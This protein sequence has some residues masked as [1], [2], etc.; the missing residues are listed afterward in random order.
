MKMTSNHVL[1]KIDWLMLCSFLAGSLVVG[2]LIIPT[3]LLLRHELQTI[4]QRFELQQWLNSLQPS[5]RPLSS[6]PI[7]IFNRLPED[8]A[9]PEAVEAMPWL[10]S[11]STYPVARQTMA[12]WIHFLRKCGAKQILID[13]D[14]ATPD[15]QDAELAREVVNARKGS[16]G[17]KAVPIHFVQNVVRGSYGNINMIQRVTEP[18]S[19]AE[20]IQIASCSQFKV[21]DFAGISVMLPDD[22]QVIRR[23]L[24]NLHSANGDHRSIIL[25][26]ARL[27]APHLSHT[28]PVLDINFIDEPNSAVFPVRPLT[29][30]VDPDRR[31]ELLTPNP[32]S[33]DVKINGAVVLIGDGISDVFNTPLTHRGWMQMS[34]TEI[35]AQAINSLV[36][37]SHITRTDENFDG[38]PSLVVCILS[39]TIAALAWL[40][41][42]RMMHRVPKPVPGSDRIF[43]F[44]S[45]IIDASFIAG[46]VVVS[47]FA[48]SL[49]FWRH[50]LL[51]PI[52]APSLAI[53]GGALT[54]IIAERNRE[55]RLAF[56]SQLELAKHELRREFVRRINHDLNAP[57]TV[58]NWALAD[59]EAINESSPEMKENIE[60]ML[61]TSDRLCM[62]L[63]EMSR[64]YEDNPNGASESIFDLREAISNSVGMLRPLAK[65]R[66]GQIECE[67]PDKPV[68]VCSP[69]PDLVRI[70]DNL[71]RN[72]FRHNPKGTMV[73][74]QLYDEGEEAEVSVSD[75]GVG[76]SAEKARQIFESPT[77][78]GGIYGNGH[79]M[80]LG[81]VKSL[82]K[83]LHG[84]I[85]L[86]SEHGKGACFN[87]RF[88]TVSSKAA[89]DGERLI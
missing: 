13:Q 88:P 85:R 61:R 54:A 50:Q 4:D 49:I 25:L 37:G 47:V 52:I 8:E 34:G 67:L 89:E 75:N 66:D 29:Y 64:T 53:V 36:S 51:I 76:I 2:L 81:I 41:W 24:L 80:G 6:T 42:C 77:P 28:D 57:V 63:D 1:R 40:L 21:D 14:F 68:Y 15:P 45:I 70:F 58:L 33:Q 82:V 39:S 43:R 10:K 65:T 87:I 20:Q 32:S 71:I 12:E 7:V 27:L 55:R 9:P 48:A 83:G 74:V 17:L 35:L 60:V 84:E 73:K 78:S 46:M 56:D 44:S 16:D 31:R 62:L 23:C 30:L 3:K 18:A 86:S 38:W 79:G 59:M 22:D 19:L 11:L 26:A 69:K 72:A 5:T